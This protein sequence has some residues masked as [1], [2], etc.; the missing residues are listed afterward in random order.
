MSLDRLF[1]GRQ[2]SEI[3]VADVFVDRKPFIEAF[4]NAVSALRGHTASAAS[5]PVQRR[6]LLVFH[7][8]G[9]IGKSRLIRRLE[10]RF[11]GGEQPESLRLS[12]R[13]DFDDQ[14]FIDTENLLIAL[15]AAVGCGS[16]HWP[17]FDLAFTV[18]WER[19]HPGEPLGKAIVRDSGLRRLNGVLDL[20][21]QIDT[22][23]DALLGPIPLA[24]LARRTV[25]ILVTRAQDKIRRDR[26]LSKC[27]GLAD[28][29]QTED[30]ADQLPYLPALLSW[31][32]ASRKAEKP[33]DVVFF[34]DTFERIERRPR[35]SG[36]PEDQLAR[37]I[38]LLPN[39]LFVA[40]GRDRVDWGDRHHPAIHYSG[41]NYWPALAAE[42]PGSP[43]AGLH[44][45]PHRHMQYQLR[46]LADSDADVY[47][48][49][50]LTLGGE[51][52]IGAAIRRSIIA[53]SGGAPLYLELSAQY[54]DQLSAA[55]GVPAP[56]Q[57]GATFAEMVIRVMRD[58]DRAERAL[59][60]A[61]SLL[62]NFDADLLRAA[63]PTVVD[64]TIGRFM[65][66]P[67]VQT[68]DT[69]WLR[70]SIDEYVRN[71]VREH[72]EDT[73]D[74]WSAQE[75]RSTALRVISYLGSALEDEAKDPTTAD[76]SRLTEAFVAAGLLTIEAGQVPDWLYD[77]AYGLRLRHF[78]SVLADTAHWPV[79]ADSPTGA[80]VLTCRGIAERDYGN[81]ATS[82]ELLEGASDHSAMAGDDSGYAS[83]FIRHRLGKALEECGRY[84]D[85]EQMI[86]QVASADSRL[87]TTA[88]KDLAWVRWLRGDGRLLESW[89]RANRH[90]SL[91]FHRGQALDLLG[92]HLLMQGEFGEA[93]QC[94]RD[95]LGDAELEEAGIVRDTAWRHLGMVLAWSQPLAAISVLDRAVEVN[96]ELGVKVGVAQTFIFR[97]VALT[98]FAPAEEVATTITEGERRLE[99]TGGSADRWM[100]LIARLFHE[101]IDGTPSG[102]LAAAG[103]LITHVIEADCH[104]GLAEIAQKWLAVRDL[105]PRVAVVP[106][107]QWTDRDRALAGW[108]AILRERLLLRR[109][110]LT[111]EGAAQA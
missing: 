37:L 80:F 40:A 61:A 86:S 105:T 78:T 91:G 47:L 102:A 62:Q 69:G 43:D 95:L 18:Y 85:A 77:L 42:S 88:Q 15:R 57:F 111:H 19:A 93:A 33:T 26:L 81:R 109:P 100:V 101:L 70:H 71:A 60:R 14:G 87:R 73:D 48:R 64:S 30:P 28:I 90:S 13:V 50:R 94:F 22:T 79:S 46:G 89:A 84:A 53:A 1:D 92:Q 9:G 35:L 63:V 107:E 66:R 54:F 49:Q 2:R 36:G 29:L 82:L 74:A 11:G 34:L 24:G 108:E 27:P 6:N 20:P 104:P 17:A 44:L 75:W 10:Q 32:L 99:A 52:A 58:L 23:I 106:G 103:S 110:P 25:A 68:R 21:G 51:P 96:T 83:L 59:L 72:D 7:G 39:V 16:R 97:G 12:G 3:E 4:D 65:K 8:L 31:D 98:G 76:R 5:A 45:P 41:P 56:E 38:Y 67:I 55:G